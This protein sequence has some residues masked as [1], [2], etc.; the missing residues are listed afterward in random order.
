LIYATAVPFCPVNATVYKLFSRDG[1]LKVTGAVQLGWPLLELQIR[2]HDADVMSVVFSRDGS[3]IVSGLDDKTI[4]IWDA[5][6][7]TE[8][9]PPMRGHSGEVRSTAFSPDGSKV[10]S[11]SDETIRVWDA[12]SG[13]EMLSPLRHIGGVHSGILT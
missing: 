10:V 8:T 7:S 1:M 2:G 13:T 4:P 6:T 11:G 5:N 12:S 9:L 3:K